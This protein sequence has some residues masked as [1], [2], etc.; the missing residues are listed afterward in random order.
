MVGEESQLALV[1]GNVSASRASV[2]SEDLAALRR[3]F[4]AGE[5]EPR[6]LLEAR[7]ELEK[8]VV[9]LRDDERAR[10][11]IDSRGRGPVRGQG[12]KG[13]G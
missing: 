7:K 6:E 5:V 12:K 3:L 11:G 1:S 9:K 13:G 4:Q 10:E 8:A 2:L